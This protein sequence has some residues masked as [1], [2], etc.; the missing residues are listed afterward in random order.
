MKFNILTI[1]PEILKYLNM[2]FSLKPLI[3]I[4]QLNATTLEIML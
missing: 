3:I 4:F 1:F 2:V